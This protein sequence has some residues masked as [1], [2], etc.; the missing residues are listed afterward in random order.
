MARD[1]Y[2]EP[3]IYARELEAIWRHDWLFVGHTVDV[4]RPGDY[5]V[6]EL[7]AD[8]VIVVRQADGS[9][10]AFHNVC[11]HRGSLLVEQANGSTRS[12]SCPYHQWTYGIDGALRAC[13]NMPGDLDMRPLGLRPA[14]VRE[15]AGLIYLSLAEAP[16]DFASAEQTMLPLADAQGLARAKIAAV[17]DYQVDANWK[18]IWENNREC[19]HCDANHPQYVQAQLDRETGLFEF[20]DVTGAVWC[21]AN[22]TELAP[23]FLTESVGGARVGPLMGDGAS[24]IGHTLRLRTLP[25]FWHHGSCDYAMTTR[26]LPAGPRRTNV[27]VSWLVDT[28]ADIARDLDLD[29]LTRFWRLTSEQDWRICER[30]QHG[31]ESS[32]YEPGPLSPSEEYNVANFISWYLRRLA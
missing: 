5:V 14:S 32:A 10:A 18:L 17:V 31:V 20:P 4:P 11:R 16:P 25:N 2:V 23:G 12:F 24:R 28:G 29:E 1:V 8:S 3:S 27:R 30:Q 26:I 15:L 19:Y 9:I 21:S 6:V 7:D 22:Q 13:R